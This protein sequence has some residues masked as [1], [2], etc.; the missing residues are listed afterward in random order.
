MRARAWLTLRHAELKPRTTWTVDPP[1]LAPDRW[2]LS[3]SDQIGERRHVSLQHHD[4]AHQRSQGEAVEEHVAEDI[5]L[6]AIPTGCRGR[7]DDALGVDH[8]AH[9]PARAVGSGHEDRIETELLGR[10]FL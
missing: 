3:P 4:D 1:E 6:V 10:D 5:T 8:L 7:Y 2:V 9:H